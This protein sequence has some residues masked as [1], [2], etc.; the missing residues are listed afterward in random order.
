M[1]GPPAEAEIDQDEIDEQKEW[2]DNQFTMAVELKDSDIEAGS[3]VVI[4]NKGAP[5]AVMRIIFEQNWTQIGKVDT[6]LS[7][8]TKTSLTFYKAGQ[9]LIL[10]MIGES[11]EA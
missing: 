9:N 5:Q 3:N 2:K 6:T 1:S 11:M 4:C 10:I 7:E 8:K